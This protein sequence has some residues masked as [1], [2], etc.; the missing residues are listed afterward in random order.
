MAQVNLPITNWGNTLLTITFILN[1]IPSKSIPIILYE[2][3]INQKL[4][5]SILK[6]WGCAA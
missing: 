3:W 4:D 5:M 6:P 1:R 2:L